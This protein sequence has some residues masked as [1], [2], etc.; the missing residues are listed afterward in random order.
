[1]YDEVKIEMPAKSKKQQIFPL[2]AE[3]VQILEKHSIKNDTEYF[4][5]N[6]ETN[7]PFV[8]IKKSF[9][10]AVKKAGLH[11]DTTFHSLRRTFGTNLMRIGYPIKTISRAMGHCSVTVTEKYLRVDVDEDIAPMVN[12]Y[13]QKITKNQNPNENKVINLQIAT[14]KVGSKV[15]SN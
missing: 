14:R 11:P 8:E 1:M 12:Y 7:K 6:P 10:S 9:K 13:S 2:S 5:L 3:A 4:F 15:G